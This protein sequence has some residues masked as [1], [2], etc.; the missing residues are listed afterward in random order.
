MLFSDLS[1][2]FTRCNSWLAEGKTQKSQCKEELLLVFFL[3]QLCTHG[4]AQTDLACSPPL[5]SAG[6]PDAHHRTWLHSCCLKQD[7]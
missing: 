3:S 5:P 4:V 2:V 7:L 6:V 1:L